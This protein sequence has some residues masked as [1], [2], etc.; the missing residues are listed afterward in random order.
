M[1]REIGEDLGVSKTGE[2]ERGGVARLPRTVGLGVRCGTEAFR[3][4]GAF[5]IV[6]SSGAIK[7]Q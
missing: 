3:P 7:C 4:S 6:L 5:A 1:E 2:G